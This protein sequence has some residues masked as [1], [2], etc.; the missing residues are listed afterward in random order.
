MFPTLAVGY[1]TSL[2]ESIHFTDEYLEFDASPL[3]MNW[4]TPENYNKLS[5]LGIDFPPIKSK[6][7]LRVLID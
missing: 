6:K 7:A 4:T 3:S 1:L 5:E 2:A